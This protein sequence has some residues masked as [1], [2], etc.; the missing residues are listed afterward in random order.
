ML[1]GASGRF[2]IVPAAYCVYADGDGRT[3]SGVGGRGWG[4]K[5]PQLV[6]RRQR[7]QSCL[8]GAQGAL[9]IQIQ[10]LLCHNKTVG[11]FHYFL[12][13]RL[14]KHDANN[15][16]KLESMVR[17]QLLMQRALSSSG[18]GVGNDKEHNIVVS[19]TSF[20]KR[21]NDVYL[22]IESLFQ[23]SVKADA[24]VLWLSTKNFPDRTLPET[25]VKQ[26]QRGLQIF[27]VEEDLGPYKKYVYAFD[28]FP[29]SLIITVDDDILYPPDTID[30][31][32]RAYLRDPAHIYCHRGHKMVLGRNGNLLPYDDWQSGVFDSEPSRLVFP[33]GMG[34]VLYFPGSLD[35]DAFDKDKFMAL[36]PNADDVWLKA[37][38][39]KQ[40]TLSARV[41]DPRHWKKRFLTIEG[42]QSHSLKRENWDRR[43]GN[44]RKIRE[45]F[46]EYGL[47]DLLS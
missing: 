19:L 36:C 29:D 14:Q 26:Q 9:R 44:D 18:P 7:L 30:L 11:M 33:T 22:C 16:L 10:F 27:F 1:F 4:I 24:I 34:G 31:L 41:A 3:G 15:N 28:Q 46:S 47:F 39:L 38:S 17:G 2:G 13:K 40:G 35:E 21:I 45:V 32:Y 42:S 37:M 25:L 5:S 23:Q 20:D 43:A 12:K 6:L 8:I